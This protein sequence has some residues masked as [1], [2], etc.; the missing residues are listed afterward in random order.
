MRI[1]SGPVLKK[2]RVD[3]DQLNHPAISSMRALFQSRNISG[4]MSTEDFFDACLGN[5]VSS[6]DSDVG[7]ELLSFFDVDGSGS[8]DAEEAEW[9]L[10]WALRQFP[11]KSL[12][13]EAT[14]TGII[15]TVILPILSRRKRLNRLRAIVRASIMSG[16]FQKVAVTLN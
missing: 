6:P 3:M 12:T 9:P 2:L 14:L 11:D 5:A 15:Q 7:R 13:L 4:A 16:K 1:K 10:L 8:I